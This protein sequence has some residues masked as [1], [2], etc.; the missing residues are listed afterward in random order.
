MASY[1]AT[2]SLYALK[3]LLTLLKGRAPSGAELHY[4][5]PINNNSRQHALLIT[6][7]VAM[8]FL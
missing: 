7:K 6:T 5:S 2:Q 4:I 8:H 3:N 1:G